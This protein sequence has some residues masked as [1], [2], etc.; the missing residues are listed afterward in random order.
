MSLSVDPVE[1]LGA[2]GTFL[3]SIA[4]LVSV[5]AIVFDEVPQRVW[6]VMVGSWWLFGVVM[7]IGA[8]ATARLR[9]AR[10]AVG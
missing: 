10:K 9:F 2:T 1:L 6:E 4:A 3:A 5:Y 8:G 7:Q